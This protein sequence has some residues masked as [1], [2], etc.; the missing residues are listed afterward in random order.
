MR[1]RH[2]YV[3]IG[4]V[5][6]VGIPWGLQGMLQQSGWTQQTADSWGP[7]RFHALW[8]AWFLGGV[9]GWF[10]GR[11]GSSW[12]GIQAAQDDVQAARDLLTRAQASWHAQQTTERAQLAQA[13]AEVTAAQQAAQQAASAAAAVQRQ[14]EVAQTALA[15]LGGAGS[16]PGAGPDCRCRTPPVECYDHGRTPQT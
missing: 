14:V 9:G 6:W 8:L 10:L 4:A 16:G 5:V 1:W 2:L 3:A 12:T 15:G 13:W 7:L 11:L